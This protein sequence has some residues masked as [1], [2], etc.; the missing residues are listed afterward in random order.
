MS[1]R[2]FWT[3]LLAATLALPA[4]MTSDEDDDDDDAVDA[5]LDGNV[6]V[7]SVTGDGYWQAEWA[8]SECRVLEIVNEH[9]AAGA[10]C[11]DGTGHH[12]PTGPLVMHQL[13]R[14]AARLHSEDMGNRGFFDHVNPDGLDPFDRMAATGFQGPY[15]WGENIAAGYPTAEAAVAGWM[16]S[17]TGHCANI[18]EPAYGVIGVGYAVVPGSQ[19]THYWTQNFA[20]GPY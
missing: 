17:E 9:R 10:D 12:P 20:G 1:Q 18:M 15:P 7:C 11:P 8:V 6:A 19:M 13:L 2:H 5:G 14:E 4:C 3:V 16:S